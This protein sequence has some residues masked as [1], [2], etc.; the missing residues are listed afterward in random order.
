M[1]YFSPTIAAKRASRSAGGPARA[2]GHVHRVCSTVAFGADYSAPAGRFPTSWA[3]R[4]GALEPVVDRFAEA[5]VRDRHDGDGGG[6]AAVERAQMREQ[7]G[8]RLDQIAARREVERRRRVLG[9][10]RP[11]TGRTRAALRRPRRAGIEPQPRARRIV[12]GELPGASGASSS[13]AVRSPASGSAGHAARSRRAA[14]RPA[15]AGSA[16]RGR[17][18]WSIPRRPASRRRR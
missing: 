18:R 7:V 13:A 10:C 9:A 6:A 12:R 5:L 4:R 8:G 2:L 1:A 11:T 14:G 16:R 15:A 17:R 3:R